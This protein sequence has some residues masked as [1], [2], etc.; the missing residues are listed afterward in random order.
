MTRTLLALLLFVSGSTVLHGTDLDAERASV[1]R[2]IETFFAAMTARDTDRMRE[3]MT[4][5]GMLYGYREGSDGLLVVRPSHEEYLSSLSKGEGE[6]VERFWEPTILLHQ[7][8][9][10]VWAPYDFHRDGE[11]S[12]CGIDNFNLLKTG[13]GW[14]ITGVVFSMETDGCGESPL[15]P[16][17][18]GS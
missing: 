4:P 1:V 7:R 16:I 11:F 17:R 18:S 2:V 9:A 6:L 10:V 15:G 14:K 12:H 5:D 13:E 3:I 8:M